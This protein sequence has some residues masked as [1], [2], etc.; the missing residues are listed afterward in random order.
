MDSNNSQQINGTITQEAANANKDQATT[1]V[2]LDTPL[3]P[4]PF[5]YITLT[6]LIVMSILSLN[7][8]SFYWF[9]KNWQAI[10]YSTK[11]HIMPFW[12]A[13]FSIFYA[14]SLFKQ[15]AEVAKKAH[16]EHV[17][18][19]TML[20]VIYILARFLVKFLGWISLL[21]VPLCLWPLQKAINFYG[22]QHQCKL[23]HQLSLGEVIT[24]LIVPVLL[25]VINVIVYSV[26]GIIADLLKLPLPSL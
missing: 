6:R 9:Y 17:V 11:R 2:A 3:E 26:Y 22:R 23:R 16:Y 4:I 18:R 24:L 1:L 25:I 20:A 14:Y 15:I 13:F 10:K 19:N 12:R 21:M 7:L 8:Y 5:L